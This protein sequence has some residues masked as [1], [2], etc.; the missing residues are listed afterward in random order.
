MN[1]KIRSKLIVF[2]LLLYLLGGPLMALLLF[3]FYRAYPDVLGGIY[4]FIGLILFLVPLIV[5]FL[6]G[7]VPLSLLAMLTIKLL[8]QKVRLYIAL[9]LNTL[10]GMLLGFIW[11]HCLNAFFGHSTSTLIDLTAIGGVISSAVYSVLLSVYAT[12]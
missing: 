7:V 8:T 9:P 2:T 10:C 5:A 1:T 6:F 12:L 11:P 4:G 3:S